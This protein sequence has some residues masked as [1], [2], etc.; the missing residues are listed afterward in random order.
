MK[1]P[2][3][4]TLKNRQGFG[5]R[6]SSSRASLQRSRRRADV[7]LQLESLEA[8]T[9]L[10]TQPQ[11]GLLPAR[12]VFGPQPVTTNDPA[13]APATTGG[14][15]YSS[16]DVIHFPLSSPYRGPLGST[17]STS[18]IGS[19]YP[20]N[21]DVG[22]TIATKAGD[23]PSPL[24]GLPTPLVPEI[25]SGY[26]GLTSLGV[27][28]ATGFFVVPAEDSLAVGPNQV[29]EATNLAI[30]FYNKASGSL[31]A[32]RC[33]FSRS[34]APWA[35][36][37]TSS[38]RRFPMT[39]P[40][41]DSS[42][43]T[44]DYYTGYHIN[45]AVS[46]DSNPLDGFSEMHQVDASEGGSFFGEFVKVGINNDAVVAAVDMFN[47]STGAFDHVQVSASTNRR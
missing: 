28:N 26:S 39:R 46:N 30:A 18:G 22:E 42:W 45:I 41:A 37:S 6:T 29:V 13:H 47:D 32:S 1:R 23:R 38:T 9:L 10:S 11:I 7:G 34:S 20:Q 25:A 3:A 14:A 43:S 35:A 4:G 27:A 21:P 36:A 19:A 16:Q 33:R 44:D 2:V 8:R 31:L 24:G 5:L 15:S 40:S 12:D 17:S